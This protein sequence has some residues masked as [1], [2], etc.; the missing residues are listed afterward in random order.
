MDIFHTGGA[1]PHSIAFGGVFLNT[2]KLTTKWQNWARNDQF[3]KKFHSFVTCFVLTASLMQ[4]PRAPLWPNLETIGDHIWKQCIWCSISSSAVLHLWKLVGVQQVR[5]KKSSRST[6]QRCHTV[7]PH[8]TTLCHLLS[9]VRTSDTSSLP[10]FSF[11][12]LQAIYIISCN[13][14]NHHQQ[15]VV[16]GPF[17][18]PAKPFNLFIKN[19]FSS[20]CFSAHCCDFSQDDFLLL[21]PPD[22]GISR[23]ENKRVTFL[24]TFSPTLQTNISEQ[25]LPPKTTSQPKH[26]AY[27]TNLSLHYSLRCPIGFLN[28]QKKSKSKRLFLTQ[29]TPKTDNFES[30]YG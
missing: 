8:H 13:K 10:T 2:T 6:Y 17:F 11:T 4:I 29:G 18:S 26:S 23:Q 21:T 1:Q 20:T 12:H 24:A 28:V 27:I 9:P 25:R 16:S 30:K 3:N 5:G 19:W 14:P 7:T 22:S 15:H